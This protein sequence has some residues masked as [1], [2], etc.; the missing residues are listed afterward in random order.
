MLRRGQD[1]IKQFI[2]GGFGNGRTAAGIAVAIAA[3]WLATGTYQ[4]QPNELGVPLIFGRAFVQLLSESF[5]SLPWVLL[6]P[7]GPMTAPT[8]SVFL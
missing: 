7:D 8:L 2:P 6:K 3:I 5:I 1:R 4:I